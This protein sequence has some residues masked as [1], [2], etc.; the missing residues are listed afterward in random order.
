MSK[1]YIEAFEKTRT[2]GSIASGAFKEVAKIINLEH[3]LM[4]SIKSVMSLLMI[5][6][7]TQPSILCGFRNHATLPIMWFVM[8]FPQIKF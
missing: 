1:N 3:G 8:V 7:L 6:G 2:A 5:M 4:K